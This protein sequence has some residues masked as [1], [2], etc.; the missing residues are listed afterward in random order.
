MLFI[1]LPKYKKK[2]IDSAPPVCFDVYVF[3]LYTYIRAL[4][5]VQCTHRGLKEE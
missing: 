3:V 5:S 4:Y 2:I 1:T